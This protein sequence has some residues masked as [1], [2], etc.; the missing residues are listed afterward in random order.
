MITVYKY[1]L[2]VM[3]ESSVWLPAG[4][5]VLKICEV[6]SKVQL[7]AKVDTDQPQELRK[8]YIHG[9]GH[10]IYV[11]NLKHIDTFIMQGGALVFHVF[12][13]ASE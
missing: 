5:E 12:E 8:F 13:E 4:A 3:D 11:E 1:E 2:P 9:T 6:Y 10:P 7:W